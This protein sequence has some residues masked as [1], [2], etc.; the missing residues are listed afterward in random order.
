MPRVC[1]LVLGAL[2]LVGCK[3]QWDPVDHDGDGLSALQGDCWDAL[4]GPEGSGLAGSDIYPGAAET[5][6]DA[7]DQDC[8]ADDDFDQD[9]DG[10]VPDEYEGFETL[11]VEGSGQLPAGGG[12][13]AA[14][15]GGVRPRGGGGQR[16]GARRRLLGRSHDRP[17]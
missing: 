8:A 4:E 6:Y 15:E 14:G 5:W 11:G 3:S 12:Q 9:G 10:Y 13:R 16:P 17:R 7:I 1:S 2:L